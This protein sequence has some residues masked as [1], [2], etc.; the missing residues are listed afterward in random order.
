APRLVELFV[1]RLDPWIAGADGHGG[2]SGDGDAAGRL[3]DEIRSLLDAVTS[4][5]E[6]LILRALMHLV[7]ATL[8]TNWFQETDAGGNPPPCVALKFDPSAIRDLPLPRP[9]FEIFVYSPRVEA[10]HL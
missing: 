4:L 10:V 5:D 9:M 1:A 3:A 2:A 7:L 6:D 8:L